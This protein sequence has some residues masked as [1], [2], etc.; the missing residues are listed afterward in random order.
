M[1]SLGNVE[2]RCVWCKEMTCAQHSYRIG[3]SFMIV[4]ESTFRNVNII[5]EVSL[6]IIM[7]IIALVNRDM[8]FVDNGWK[9]IGILAI[10]YTL[11]LIY[12]INSLGLEE[13]WTFIVFILFIVL[14]IN[15]EVIFSSGVRNVSNEYSH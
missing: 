10:E 11:L 14:F 13:N 15:P 12:A 9:Y 2:M 1:E 4:R 8:N 5:V 7:L 6:I 3:G